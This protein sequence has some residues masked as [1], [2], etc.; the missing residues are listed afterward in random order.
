MFDMTSDWQA[1]VF[2]KLVYINQTVPI[3]VYFSEFIQQLFHGIH[4]H[5]VRKI[6][7]TDKFDQQSDFKPKESR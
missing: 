4:L 5:A 1:Q 2:G 3:R 6:S 7:N